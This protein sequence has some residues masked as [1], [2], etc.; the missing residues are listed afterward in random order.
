MYNREN[1]IEALTV[2][3]EVCEKFEA[4]RCCP[5]YSDD[6]KACLMEKEGPDEWEIITDT[7]PW[8]AIK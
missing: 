7:P 4:C 3:K 1:L 2:I 5:M 6:Y 8:R